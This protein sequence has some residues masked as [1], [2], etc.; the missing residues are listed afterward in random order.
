MKSIICLVILVINWTVRINSKSF[1]IKYMDEGATIF[2]YFYSKSS[3]G[4]K[5]TIKSLLN[6]SS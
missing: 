4:R 1:Q 3:G 5:L 6:Q 2:I